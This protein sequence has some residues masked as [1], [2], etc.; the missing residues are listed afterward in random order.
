MTLSSPAILFRALVLLILAITPAFAD[1]VAAQAAVKEYEAAAAKRDWAGALAAAER[2]VA[3]DPTWGEAWADRGFAKQYNLYMVAAL[4]D[5]DRAIRIDEAAGPKDSI[6]VRSWRMRRLGTLLDME[7]WI[8]ALEEAQ[9]LIKLNSDEAIAYGAR[10]RALAGLGDVDGG[11]ADLLKAASMGGGCPHYEAYVQ[12]LKGDWAAAAVAGKK[13]LEIPTFAPTGLMWLVVA[14]SEQGKYTEAE[15]ALKE[16][17]AKNPAVRSISMGKAWVHGTPAAGTLFNYED[18]VAQIAKSQTRVVLTA[19]TTIHARILFVNGRLDEC[20]D[21]LT[22]KGTRSEFFA[23]LWLGAAQWSLGQFADARVTL[24]DARRLNSSLA[25]HAKAVPGLEAFVAAIDRDL[26]SEAKAADRIKLGIELATYL[27]SSAEIET[28]VRRYQF[29]RAAAEYE[30]LLPTLTS[31]VRKAEVEARVK[32]IRGMAGALDKLVASINKGTKL[33]TT[34]ARLELSIVKSDDRAFDF[35]IPNGSGKFPWAYLDPLEFFK[36]ASGPSLSPQE[37]FGLGVLLW[38][39]GLAAEGQKALDAPVKSVPALK[40]TLDVL[41]AKRRGIASPKGGFVLFRGMWVTPEEK[42]QLE[43]G[44]VL[45][46]G[47][48]V[49]RE[50]REKLAKGQIKVGDT[51]VAGGEPELLKRGYR[52]YKDAWMT[53]EDYD[54]VRQ[55]WADAWEQET[56]HYK[57]RSNETE[58]FAGDLATLIEAAWLEYGKFYPGVTPKLPEGEK[59]TLW[60]FR[61]YE[62][63]R[64]HCVETKQ[65]VHLNAAGFAASDSNT[66]VGWNKT[67]NRQL[68]LATMVHEAAHLYYFRVAAPKS[69]PSWHAEGMATYFE[70][71]AW[72]GAAWKFGTLPEGRVQL[73]KSAVRSGTA[74]GLEEMTKAD[75]LALI[76]SDAQKALLFYSEAWSLNYFLTH[77][78]NAA[79]RE[80]YLGWRRAVADGKESGLGEFFTDLPALEKDWKAFVGS[81]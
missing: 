73:V 35:T 24:A 62:D 40:A 58:Q 21:L 3:A 11:L 48:W 77:T 49:T 71:F 78:G 51:W 64:R 14:L 33:A 32:E 39:V 2:A 27:L 74:I 65:E 23:L 20:V 57:I 1:R 53:R 25:A 63:Y 17:E 22:S 59:M 46:R 7:K 34:V 9:I 26:A 54:A 45:Y 31:P 56:V 52:K 18:A 72:D 36:F 79:Y 66:V 16:Y 67:A 44:M 19:I 42:L 55:Q 61:T 69:L 38:D 28:L 81:L 70:G 37:R 5:F 30:K 6:A 60:A 68:F 4:E 29:K 13:A 12:V 10:G 50:E 47:A 8:A 76:N 41:V 75:A 43:K 80:A 15:A